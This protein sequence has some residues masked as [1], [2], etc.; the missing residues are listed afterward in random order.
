MKDQVCELVKRCR[1]SR[2]FRSL[3]LWLR[4]RFASRSPR[5]LLTVIVLFLGLGAI[6]A[7][8]RSRWLD[9][10]DSVNFALAL[11]DFD[12]GKSQPH[13]P[14][15]PIYIGAAKLVHL[16]VVDPAAALTLVSSLAGAVVA[17]M[18]YVLARRQLVWSVAL[19]STI[20]MALTPLFWLQAELALSDMFGLIFVLSFL[21]VEGATAKTPEGDLA[22]RIACGAIAGL[23]LGA[24]PHVTLLIVAYWCIRAL[25]AR[26]INGT[27][28]LTATA[29]FVLGLILW[30]VPT[31]LATGGLRAYLSACLTQ[32]EWRLD[33]PAASI[34]GG[35]ISATYLLARA[36]GFIGWLGQTFAPFQF[37]ITAKHGARQIAMGLAALAPY[38]Y[39][40][41][42]SAS[43]AVARPYVIASAMYLLMLFI[44]LPQ[45]QRYFLPFCLIVGWSVA[46][47]LELFRKPVVRWVACTALLVSNSAPALFLVRALM[48]SMP[49]TVAALVWGE[50]SH[51]ATALYSNPVRRQADYYFP[52]GSVRWEPQTSVECANFRQ[53][54]S[55]ETAVFATSPSLCGLDGKIVTSF[56]RDPRIHDKNNLVSIFEFMAR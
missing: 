55:L 4:S 20:V 21:L 38:V 3:D 11:D 41:W 43:K 42:Q 48:S 15:Y 7:L 45:H 52:E 31:M 1:V 47:F 13:P 50:S 44:L 18:F 16:V 51:S 14:G 56:R 39:F 33:K 8:T 23:S 32:F 24:R 34:L 9:D 40:A 5:D 28:F 26:S 27:H 6:F 35:P 53:E 22:Q 25:S 29:S 17:A 30:L 2:D 10:W 46:G 37:H 12:I 36:S 19:A 49:P 54:L